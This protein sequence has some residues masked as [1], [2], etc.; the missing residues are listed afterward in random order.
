MGNNDVWSCQLNSFTWSEPLQVSFLRVWN[1]FFVSRFLG[2][3]FPYGH[4]FATLLRSETISCIFDLDKGLHVP[5]L[6]CIKSV[7][8]QNVTQEKVKCEQTRYNEG[9]TDAH[10]NR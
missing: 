2:D 4:V 1:S 3:W 10:F 5:Q 8:V 6:Y 9:V 7:L